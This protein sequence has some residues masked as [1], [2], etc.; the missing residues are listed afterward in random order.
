MRNFIRLSVLTVFIVLTSCTTIRE[1]STLAKCEFKLGSI[2]DLTLVG[3]NIQKINSITD[4]S[5]GDG[6][7]IAAAIFTSSFPL[8]FTLNIDVKNPNKTNAALNNLE[9]ILLIDDIQMV[10]GN[11]NKRVEIAPNGGISTLPININFDLKEALS[12]KSF[13]SIKN[14]AFNL[15][16][17]GS[18]P[19]RVTLKAKPTIMIGS[20]SIQYPGYISIK[21]QYT[22]N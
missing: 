2:K 12:G 17:Y 13:E 16:G 22:S 9:W 6:A 4:L 10:T 14:F 8:N 5:W 19:T 1:L 21:T 7:K 15:A 11:V 20:K 3:V 18:G